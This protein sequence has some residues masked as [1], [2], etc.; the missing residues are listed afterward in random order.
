MGSAA[1]ERPRP[2]ALLRRIN[3][4][5]RFGFGDDALLQKRAQKSAARRAVFDSGELWERQDGFAIRRYQSYQAY[6]DHQATKLDR[7]SDRLEETKTEDFLEFKRR[8]EACAALRAAR[9]VLCLGARLGT[10][11]KA[12]HAL[13]HFAVGV[14]LNPG[15]ENPYVL[16]GDFHALV[17]PDG[18]TDAIYTNALDHVFDLVRVMA[19]VRRVLRPG[20]GLFVVDMLDGYEEGFTPG[21]YESVHWASR[22]ALQ[23]EIAALGGLELLEARELGQHRRDR[24]TQ[25]V[26]RKDA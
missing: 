1:Q 2:L 21:R 7:V 6:L 11:V 9:S 20:G 16:T 26:F 22:E 13:G 19:E 14:D 15:Q 12:L 18:S 17:F 8:F 4:I 25:V 3:N 24:W 5:L 23:A 10:E